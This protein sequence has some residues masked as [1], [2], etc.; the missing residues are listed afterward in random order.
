LG[1]LP[2]DRVLSGADQNQN[3][4]YPQQV[5]SVKP[6]QSATE[7]EIVVLA[8]SSRGV[9]QVNRQVHQAQ[10]QLADMVEM[11]GQLDQ[12]FEQLEP[13]DTTVNG[14]SVST[15]LTGVQEIKDQIQQVQEGMGQLQNDLETHITD[16]I[17]QMQADHQPEVPIRQMGVASQVMDRIRQQISGQSGLAVEAQAAGI[18]K[19][20]LPSLHP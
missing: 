3:G 19:E 2:S 9:Q 13:P 18:G 6:E 16:W 12:A 7:A 4:H 14:A 8:T 10:K 1:I 5:S 17:H 11:L 20:L 15:P